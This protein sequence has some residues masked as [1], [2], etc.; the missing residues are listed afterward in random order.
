MLPP[1]WKSDIQ[2]AIA[3][4]TNASSER[5]NAQREQNATAIA[6]EIKCL[7]QAYNTQHNKP[8]RRDRLKR[9]L[10]VGT[11]LLVLGTTIFTGLAWWAFKGQL[12]V[13]QEQL[14]EMQNAYTPIKQSA[15]AAQKA[16]EV[17]EKTLVGTQRAFVF[18][19]QF[20]TSVINNELQI[21]PQWENSGSTPTKNARNWTL[22]K[23]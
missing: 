5:Q 13:F 9:L 7:V 22:L 16:A 15:D 8:E 21:L 2:K 18:V 20:E 23:T 19:R 6:K 17:A 10:D 11:F 1:S 12:H 3:K 14:T 4:T